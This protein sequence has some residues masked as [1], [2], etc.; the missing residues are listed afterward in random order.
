MP[1]GPAPTAC[2][3]VAAQAAPKAAAP[4]VPA[5]A[6]K[7]GAASATSTKMFKAIRDSLGYKP[8]ATD[9]IFVPS[10]AAFDAFA[11]RYNLSSAMDFTN[12]KWAD[13]MQTVG[14]YHIHENGS[15]S[16]SKMTNGMSVS[17]M[18]GA[19]ISVGMGANGMMLKGVSNSAKIMK[20]DMTDGPAMVH[21]IDKV[22]IPPNVYTSLYEAATTRSDLK[23]LGGLIKA[24]ANLKEKSLNPLF[25]GTYF[26]VSDAGFKKFSKAEN[27]TLEE[28]YETPGRTGLVLVFH[29]APLPYS[30]EAL[31][32][33]P[34]GGTIP[35]MLEIGSVPEP[36]YYGKSSS[37]VVTLW[38]ALNLKDH[39]KVIVKDINIGAGVMQII[40]FPLLPDL[41]TAATQSI[42]QTVNKTED[43]ST[44]SKI[45]N[46]TGILDQLDTPLF[47]G[48]LFAPSNEAF[49]KFATDMGFA[50]IA[51]VLKIEP[52][53]DAIL[54]YH[55]IPIAYSA[56]KL[57]LYEPF[58]IKPFRG[59]VLRFKKVDDKLQVIGDHN[60]AT[61]VE[62]G[63]DAGRSVVHKIDAVLLPEQVFTTIMSAL[64]YFSSSAIIQNLVD[65]TPALSAVVS[66]P[67][68]DFTLFIPK[69][70]AFLKQ[71]PNVVE[72]L[73]ADNATRL[74]ALQNHIVAGARFVPSGFKNGDKLE[75]LL[76]QT[77]T[78]TIGAGPMDPSTKTKRGELSVT[79]EGGAT[80]KVEVINIVAGQSVLHGINRV[81]IPKV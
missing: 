18:N 29:A 34:P 46:A 6:T 55:L 20:M 1:S 42:A 32:K 75:T 13:L 39:A 19:K 73:M 71:G 56:D 3:G 2:A 44:L 16:S 45:I 79:S 49:D 5:V 53:M 78:V 10:D 80:A 57:D 52:L 30:Y 33:L 54:A 69:N 76:K 63:M 9:T 61:V 28:A 50:S 51:D 36:I 77:L 15:M 35:S 70:E 24:Q 22:L 21:V 40:D 37:G 4:K 58:T 31:T 7:P 59:G 47:F 62:Q 41:E 64:E 74:E 81:L 25:S 60:T 66:D 11:K 27:F 8:A 43:L 65:A 23:I 17:T 68:S 72:R 12:P 48:T 67:K 26:A 14:S 38:G